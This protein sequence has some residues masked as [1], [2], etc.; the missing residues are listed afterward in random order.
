MSNDLSIG[1]RL[2]RTMDEDDAYS[3]YKYFEPWDV[4]DR[5]AEIYKI[6]NADGVNLFHDDYVRTGNVGKHPF[7]S[8]YLLS[9]KRKRGTIGPSQGGKSLPAL[10]E[11]GCMASG[12]FPISLQYDKGEDS[13]VER[14]VTNL[15]IRRRGRFS[16]ETGRVIDHDV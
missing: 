16:K 13:G 6:A 3:L 7:Q 15:N 5:D 1:A 11:I 9:T 2:Q 14:L 8:G 10:I 4:E 12:E